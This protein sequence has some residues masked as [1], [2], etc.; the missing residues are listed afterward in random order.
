[1]RRFCLL[2]LVLTAA[3]AQSRV[4]RVWDE[5]GL[6]GW[7][8]P[9]AGQKFSAGHFTEAEYYAAPVDN[10]RTYPVYF[11]GRE[12]KGFWE[13]LTTAGPKPLIEPDKIKTEADWRQAG[14]RVFDELDFAGSRTYT[15]E[16]IRKLR[17]P[18]Y[19]A[20]RKIEPL[21]DGT[22]PYIRWV[23]TE[24][25]VAVSFRECAGCHL[26][27]I[28]GKAVAGPASNMAFPNFDFGLY[29]YG[30]AAYLPKGDDA[31]TARW[32]GHM[33]PWVKDDSHARIKTMPVKEWREWDEASNGV[34]MQARWDG[35]IYYPTKMPDLIGV[36]DRKYLDATATHRHRGMEDLMRYG[37]QVASADSPHFGPYDILPRADRHVPYRYS[38]ETWYA[39]AKY[40]YS[41]EPPP[42]PNPKDA[43]AAAG[44]KLFTGNCAGCHPAPLYTN[45][46]L[47]LAKGYRPTAADLANPDV[48]PISVGTDPG[49]ATL[50]RKATGF[51][52]VPSLKG[53]WY[54]ARLLH[55]GSLSTLEEMFNPARLN[56][57]FEPKGWNPPGVKKRAVAGHEFGLKLAEPERRQLIA[58]LRTL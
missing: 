39:A 8:L 19:M 41:L 7:H 46:K 48:M 51:Y 10:L 43:A 17:S 21:P 54:R 33:V 40:I 58:F 18:A 26:A 9:I 44:E 49:G 11:P 12:P 36:K 24:R 35:S 34:G 3:H 30:S 28:G 56:P 20:E 6:A 31:Q 32:R 53:V 2:F 23:V 14:Q 5:K 29:D 50:T 22:I 16:I 47:T 55:D 27:W 42:N 52:R 38:D 25:G 57:D 45:N 1:M 37:A 13:T 4:P 15:S